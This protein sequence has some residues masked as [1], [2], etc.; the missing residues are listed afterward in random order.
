M[1]CDLYFS[2]ADE[3]TRNKLYGVKCRVHILNGAFQLARQWIKKPGIID[4]L[5]CM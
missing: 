3:G 2:P 4:K 5:L 1:T